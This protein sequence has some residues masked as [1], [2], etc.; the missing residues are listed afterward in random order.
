MII[1][2]QS[3]SKRT[4]IKATL[5]GLTAVP[6]SNSVLADTRQWQSQSPL[7]IQVQELYPT[8]HKE[9][10]YVAGGIAAR[11]GV[12]Y[13]TNR[14]FCYNPQRNVWVETAKLPIDLHHVALVSTQFTST[15]HQLYALG[16]FNGAYSHIWRMRDEVYQLQENTWHQ[17]AT[18]PKP[19][20]EGVVAAHNNNVHIVTGQSPKGQN[21]SDRSD[22]SEVADHYIWDGQSFTTA[23]PIPTVRNSATGGWVS[24]HLV[25]TGGRTATGNLST[26]EVYDPK[27]DKWHN[28]RPMPK[29]QAG[30][31]SVVVGDELWVFGGEIFQPKAYVFANCW[32]YNF[33]TDQWQSLPDMLTPRHGLGAGKIGNTVYIIGGAT[34]PGGSGTSGLNESLTI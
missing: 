23:A 5:G 20:A 30:T 24:G 26:T 10:L 31:A 29:S 4:F 18:L 3:L 22:H 21:N 25:V 15:S 34:E 12:P 27:Q 1:L 13:F 7:P 9:Q 2:R 33:N 8:V 32:R 14:S 16:G 6:L 17:V 28:A 19:L 11:L